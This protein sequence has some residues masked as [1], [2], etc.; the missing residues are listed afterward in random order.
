[1]VNAEG[2]NRNEDDKDYDGFE[3]LNAD[4]RVEALENPMPITVQ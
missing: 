2:D 1:M 4:A 3:E